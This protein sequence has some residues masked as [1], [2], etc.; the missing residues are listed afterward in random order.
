LAV[1]TL[2]AGATTVTAAYAG[3]ANTAGSAASIVQN[4]E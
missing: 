3:N 1:T 4:V 2:P